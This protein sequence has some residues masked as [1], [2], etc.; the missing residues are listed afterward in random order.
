MEFNQL[1]LTN[2]VVVGPM[3]GVTDGVFRRLAWEQ[4]PALAWTEMISAQ[5]LLYDNDRTWQMA[6]P[7]NGEGSVVVQLFGKEPEYMAQAAQ[8]VAVLKPV[9]IDINMGCPAP[10]IVKNGEGSA[11]LQQPELAAAIVRA[12][13]QAVDLPVLVKIRSGW[14]EEQK[15]AVEM[16]KLLAGSGAAA[17]TVHGRTRMQFYS[18]KADWDIIRQVKEAVSVPV[19]GNGDVFTPEAAKNMLTTTGCDAVMLARGVLGNLWLIGRTVHYLSTGVLSPEPSPKERLELALRQLKLAVEEKGDRL[20]VA[21]MRKHLSWY[22]K[23]LPGAARLRAKIMEL[24]TSDA[25]K[26]VLEAY[27]ARLGKEA[28]G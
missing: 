7:L 14:D 6:T 13:S 2:H 1:I 8:K 18:G 12:V 22:L 17:I 19:I 26:D 24:S 20:G 4:G 28:R 5:A 27:F 23:G 21:E 9:A 15:N 10:K 16:A 3:A 25:V 11:L